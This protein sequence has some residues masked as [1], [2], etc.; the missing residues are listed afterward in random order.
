MWTPR[1]PGSGPN[2][3]VLSVNDG[4]SVSKDPIDFANSTSFGQNG[5]TYLNVQN[6]GGNT[7]MW[8]I[9]FEL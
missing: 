1:W 4:E 7:G 5:N 9:V 6:V 8:K 3:N 2:G